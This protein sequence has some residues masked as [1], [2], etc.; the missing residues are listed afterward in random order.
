MFKKSKKGFTLIELLVVIAIIGLLS[1]LA[2][3]ALGSA[4]AKGR[5]A[6]RIADVNQYKTALEIF[7]ADWGNYPAEGEGAPVKLGEDVTCLDEGGFDTDCSGASQIYIKFIQKS[8][9]PPSNSAYTYE[10]KTCTSGKCD[11]YEISFVL[12]SPTQGLAAGVPIC[13]TPEGI[14]VCTP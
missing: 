2:V 12:E 13:A 5:D 14:Q 1:T 9:T 11:N 7:Y 10:A 6:R 3:V 4:R 8:P